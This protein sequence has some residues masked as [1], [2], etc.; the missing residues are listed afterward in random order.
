MMGASLSA[1]LRRQYLPDE[2]DESAKQLAE[3]HEVG[4]L[5]LAEPVT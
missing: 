3:D 4:E 1:N 2:L 5:L